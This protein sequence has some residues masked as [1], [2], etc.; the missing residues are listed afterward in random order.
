MKISNCEKCEYFRHRTWST[1]YKPK[2]YHPIGISH[3]YGYCK[4]YENRCGNIK[5]VRLNN[6]I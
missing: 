4:L 1:Y 2:D 3:A 6:G 5:N